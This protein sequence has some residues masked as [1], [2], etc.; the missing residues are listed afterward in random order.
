[1]RKRHLSLTAVSGMLEAPV[2]QKRELLWEEPTQSSLHFTAYQHGNKLTS[3]LIHHTQ[4]L[5]DMIVIIILFI[6]NSYQS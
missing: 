1:M 3:V 2:Q 4:C 5:L 6:L